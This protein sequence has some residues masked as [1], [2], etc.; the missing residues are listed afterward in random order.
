[1]RATFP[2]CIRV[3]VV[4]LLWTDLVGLFWTSSD[5]CCCSISSFGPPCRRQQQLLPDAPGMT[6][7]AKTTLAL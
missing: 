2:M 1:M 6:K 5:P 3:M 7:V 4:Q